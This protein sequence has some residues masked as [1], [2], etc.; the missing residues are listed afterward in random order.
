MDLAGEVQ[1][2]GRT[3]ALLEQD[4]PADQGGQW[5]PREARAEINSQS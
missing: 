1:G 2:G 5:G 3:Q 4:T